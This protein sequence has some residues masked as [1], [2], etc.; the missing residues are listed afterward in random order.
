M[1]IV[2]RMFKMFYVT[3]SSGAHSH[4]T[5]WVYSK[6]SITGHFCMANIFDRCQHKNYVHAWHEVHAMLL[7]CS[8]SFSYMHKKIVLLDI[9]MWWTEITG[10]KINSRHACCVIN[11]KKSRERCGSA[12]F[13]DLECTQFRLQWWHSTTQ[14]ND[15]W[16]CEIRDIFTW[17]AFYAFTAI[18]LALGT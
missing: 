5:K 2:S 17:H 9:M 12:S 6:I 7:V 13:N 11:D 18:S 4:I 16:Y 14:L 10:G 15:G 3:R 8:R 1:P